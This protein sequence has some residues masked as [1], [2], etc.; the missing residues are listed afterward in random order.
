MSLMNAAWPYAALLLLPL[1]PPLRTRRPAPPPRT[2]AP[3]PPRSAT[4]AGGQFTGVSKGGPRH[5]E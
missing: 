2:V 5:M 1:H 4:P 3:H